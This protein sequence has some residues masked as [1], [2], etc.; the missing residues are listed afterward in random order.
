[1]H[2]KTKE[3]RLAVTI[4]PTTTLEVIEKTQEYLNYVKEHVL[5]VRKAWGEVQDKC[6]DMR[7]MYDDFYYFSI[8]DSV[9]FHDI[10]KLSEFEF[11]QY[12]RAFY[13][14]KDEPK[15]NMDEAWEHHKKYNPHHWEN[16]TTIK[17]RFDADWEVHC[18]HMVIDWIAMGYKFGDTA[19][20]FYEKNKEKINIPDY[21]VRFINEIF[22]RVYGSTK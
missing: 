1:M 6:K 16:W 5:N 9:D 15:Y 4:N 12:R 8:H 19:R 10:S 14:A 13:P 21:A 18:V 17:P 3:D 11:V 2:E 20:D 22:D 7:F